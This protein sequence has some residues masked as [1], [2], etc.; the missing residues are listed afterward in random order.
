MSLKNAIFILT[1]N[2]IERKVYLKTCLYFLFKNFNKNYSYPVIIF[3][4]GDYTDIK[5]Q[6]EIIKSVR[7]KYRG[8]INFKKLDEDDFKIPDFIDIN[9]MNKSIE[10]YP[11]PYW[12]NDR[13]RLMCRWWLIHFNK[14]TD[15]YDYVMR[16]DDDSIIEEPINNDLFNLM[17]TKDYMYLSN[18]LHLDC[19]LC[20][21]K[22]KDIFKE[23][24]PDKRELLN[25]LFVEKRLENTNEIFKKFKEIIENVEDVKYEKNYIDVQMPVMY[26]NNFFITN[27]SFW[28]R[29]EVIDLMDKIDKTGNIFY[30]RYGD[31]P[32]QTIIV[33]LMEKEKITRAVF[34]YSKRLQRESF[35]DRN[36]NI[37]SYMPASYENTS[38]ITYK[39]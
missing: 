35:I 6:E 2:T 28:K 27:T 26:Y 39:E 33:T 24:L 12:R 3:H 11:V 31:A 8:C 22:M 25:E 34:K 36:N 13:Y 4:E 20:C 23:I 21:Y 30:Y 5:E 1:Q 19:G 17:K 7:E 18:I 15:A 9:K 10:L 14:Y 29:K 32:I 16:L 38:C 37:H